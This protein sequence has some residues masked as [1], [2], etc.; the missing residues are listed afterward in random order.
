MKTYAIAKNTFSESIRQPIIYILILLGIAFLLLSF[1]FTLFTFSEENTLKMIKDMG[2]ATITLCSLLVALFT[3]SGVIAEEIEKKT[4]LTVLCKPV[5][6]LQFLLGKYL[7]ILLVVA[8]TIAVLVAVFLVALWFQE[9]HIDKIV[10]LAAVFAFLQVAVLTAISVGIS[11]RFPLVVNVAVCF[12]LYVAG[13]T[14][15]YI[16]AG[17][18]N[19]GPILRTCVQ[20]ALVILPNLENLNVASLAAKGIAVSFSCFAFALIYAVLYSVAVLALALIALEHREM[21]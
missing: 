5:T 3:A 20:T 4:A 14:G 21:M 6:R 11:T 7:G 12:L 17:F 18:S 16:A 8:C 13:H 9:R 19:K 15:T 1:A 10:P 2:L